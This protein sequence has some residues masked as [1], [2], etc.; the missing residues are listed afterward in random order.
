MTH[1]HVIEASR[2]DTFDLGV[3]TLRVLAAADQTDGAFAVGEFSG[4]QAGPW[5]V[6]HIHRRTEESFYVL[7]GDFTFTLGD[8]DVEAR[9]GSFLLVPRGMPHVMRSSGRG[10]SFP[11]A[12]VARRPRGDVSGIEPNAVRQPSGP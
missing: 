6:P 10:R 1:A 12:L 5:T 4:D 3:V 7:D 2:G 9:P 11:D 8:E